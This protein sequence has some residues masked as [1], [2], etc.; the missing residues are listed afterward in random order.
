ML[1][2]LA[3]SAAVDRAIEAAEPKRLP[4]RRRIVRPLPQA[5]VS[6]YAKTGRPPARKRR[7]QTA[8]AE[9]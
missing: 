4:Q 7:W 1:A 9:T 8:H 6:A 3:W 5:L 2:W